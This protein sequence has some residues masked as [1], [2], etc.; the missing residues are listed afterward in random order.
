MDA[1]L[2]NAYPASGMT[3]NCVVTA[4]GYCGGG[5]SYK[6]DSDGAQCSLGAFG[7]AAALLLFFCWNTPCGLL[8]R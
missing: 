2:Q 5:G 6:R 1:I 3:L 8:S 4:I 7:A